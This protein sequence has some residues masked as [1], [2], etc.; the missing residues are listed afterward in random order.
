MILKLLITHKDNFIQSSRCV[1]QMKDT[2]VYNG[3]V[4]P[5]EE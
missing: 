4:Q 1:L 3:G 5:K 2:S